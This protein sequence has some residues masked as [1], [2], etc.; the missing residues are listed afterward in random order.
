MAQSPCFSFCALAFLT[1]SLAAPPVSAA[2]SG[3][4]EG[5]FG[6]FTK[7]ASGKRIALAGFETKNIVAY[8]VPDG[9]EVPLKAPGVHARVALKE[10]RFVPETIIVTKGQTVD[11]PNDGKAE[12]G[13]F[14]FSMAKKFDLGDYP[15]GTS[16]SV[17][18]EKEGAVIL[19]C[20]TH[21]NMIGVIYVAPTHLNALSD[22][23]G[24]FRISGVPVGKYKLFTWH[25]NLPESVEFVEVAGIDVKNGKPVR[26]D[27]NLLRAGQKKP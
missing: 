20:S 7:D 16:K 14:S 22:A 5:E 9:H 15:R 3:S 24:Q 26:V 11:F 6:F 23:A 18:F 25:K 21:E 4:V 17:V 8:L 19:L 12:Q 2:E 27:I 10:A 13:V 1:L